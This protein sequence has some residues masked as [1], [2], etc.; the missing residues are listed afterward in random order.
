[1]ATQHF[2]ERSGQP[3]ART[4]PATSGPLK[5]NA[6][7]KIRIAHLR[8]TTTKE[9]CLRAKA[10]MA[11][12]KAEA[13]RGKTASGGKPRHAAPKAKAQEQAKAHKKERA[14]VNPLIKSLRISRRLDNQR[15]V[16][17]SMRRY[18]KIG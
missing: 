2:K 9:E 16:R 15:T 10:R 3:D 17:T 8:M 5:A 11:E 14:K 4:T 12:A 1:M 7:A 6:L 13:R 18:A